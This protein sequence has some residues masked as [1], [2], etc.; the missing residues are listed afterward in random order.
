[1]KRSIWLLMGLILFFTTT[2]TSRTVHSLPEAGKNGS[3]NLA[4]KQPVRA[5]GYD[6]GFE[7]EYAVDGLYDPFL[8]PPQCWRRSG[9]GEN[10]IEVTF[11]GKAKLERVELLLG[12]GTPGL[13]FSLLARLSN[14]KLD[15]LGS[16]AGKPDINGLLSVDIPKPR[17]GIA[18]AR[19]D[20]LDPG[21]PCIPEIS[22]IGRLPGVEQPVDI[23]NAACLASP[24]VIFH[25]GTVIT[26][27]G[28]GDD[29]IPVAEAAAILGDRIYATGSTRDIRRM[30][31]PCTTQVDLLGLTLMPGFVDTHS[32]ALEHPSGT[33]DAVIEEQQNA[34]LENGVTTIGSLHVNP[35]NLARIS[36]FNDAGKLRV[37]TGLYMVYNDNCDNPV[38]TWFMAHPPTR[39]FGEML[40]INGVKIFADGTNVS[41]CERAPFLTDPADLDPITPPNPTIGDE[42]A[43]A[44]EIAMVVSMAQSINL[45]VAI[46]AVGDRAIEN[47]LDGIEMGLARTVGEPKNKFRHRIEHNSVIREDQYRRYDEIGVVA[48]IPSTYPS[49][50]DL[51]GEPLPAHQLNWE[52]PYAALMAASPDAHFAWQADAPVHPLNPFHA[53]FG[54]VTGQDVAPATGVV[55]TGTV[56]GNPPPWLLD[57]RLQV[58]RAL[59]L[60]TIDGAY[61]LFRETEVG[62][63]EEGKLADL[64]VVT[65]NP[66]TLRPDDFKDIDVL[67]TMVGGRTEYCAPGASSVCP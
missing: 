35:D 43:D 9:K 14:G 2:I 50:S 42:F 13:R 32:H 41:G 12:R 3:W 4:F 34:I 60:M 54:F 49:C 21:F 57:S 63:L 19:I 8:T 24:D 59:H 62:S 1:M 5:S 31:G 47:A 27:E 22:L 52:W 29:P 37:R 36:A 6:K 33:P 7:P 40:R 20:I 26:M 64:I 48:T 61:A 39:R 58:E 25:S 51:F 46:H 53:L 18:G 45:Q 16:F 15:N 55:C 23:P 56:Y 30:A 66:L 38:G 17:G 44:S 65:G 28:S 67:M 10:W 11:A